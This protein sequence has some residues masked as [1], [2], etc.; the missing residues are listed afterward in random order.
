MTAPTTAV[1]TAEAVRHGTLTA[2]A[3]A[4]AALDRIERS[5][6]TTN[7]WQVVRRQQALAEADQVDARAEQGGPGNA[8]PIALP[9]C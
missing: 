1:A 6:A 5:Q 9:D 3:A 2:R 8:G 4:E 7:A